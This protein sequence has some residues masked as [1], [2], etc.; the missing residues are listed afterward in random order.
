MVWIVMVSFIAAI[1][2]LA[3]MSYKGAGA[4]VVIPPSLEIP[5]RDEQNQPFSTGTEFVFEV[6]EIATGQVTTQTVHVQ[7]DGRVRLG[8]QEG[9]WEIRAG[10]GEAYEY[11][12]VNNTVRVT[13][14]P[15]VFGECQHVVFLVPVSSGFV[16]VGS[17]VECSAENTECN[18]DPA[19]QEEMSTRFWGGRVMRIN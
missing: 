17:A 8:L 3:I 14:E 1:I 12:A 2:I 5:L 16:S 6:K 19:S 9:Q 10:C 11:L 7:S 18:V 4:Q 13:S 15:L